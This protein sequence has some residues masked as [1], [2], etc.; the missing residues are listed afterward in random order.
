MARAAL[1][2]PELRVEVVVHVRVGDEADGAA[3][4]QAGLSP[5]CSDGGHERE[6]RARYDQQDFLP[7]SVYRL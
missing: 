3:R 5:R 1:R 4:R 2:A 7:S 6:R